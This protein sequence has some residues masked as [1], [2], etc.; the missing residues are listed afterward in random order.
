M[1][2]RTFS[3]LLLFSLLL[4]PEVTAA[5]KESAGPTPAPLK[6]A[7]QYNVQ[8]G[9]VRETLES[10]VIPPKAGAPFTLNL[11]TE[12]IKTLYDGGT[13][14]S[15]NQ[16]RIAR[17]SKG[18]IYQERWFLV[19]KNG[20]VESQ[21]T[22]I[23]ISDPTAH[24]HYNCFMLEKPHQ[25]VLSYFAPSTSAVFKQGVTTGEMPNDQG[26]TI[27]EELGKQ[28]ISGIETTG[29]RDSV[30]YNPWVFGN[31]R[32]ATALWEYW[33][34]PELGVN[35]LSIV[36]DPRFGKQVFTVTDVMLGEPDVKLFDLP[37]GFQVVDRRPN[38]P[39]KINSNPT[40]R[41]VLE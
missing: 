41:E 12:W 33:Y 36:S 11:Q 2:M 21:M 10:I 27:H 3:A 32:K 31:D 28:L 1:N 4:I 16:R 24:T 14:T 40:P 20:K 38:N 29:T 7:P 39:P 23:Q 13:I 37:E 30:I 6:A 19:P 17:D 34:S 35:L 22:T 9:G 5:Q 18:R 26:S 15:V 8:D 25:C